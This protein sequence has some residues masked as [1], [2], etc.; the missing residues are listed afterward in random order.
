MTTPTHKK[1]LQNIKCISFGGAGWKIFYYYGIM[2]YL[3][4][5]HKSELR[6]MKIGGAS[7]GAWV[8]LSI[9]LEVD[10]DKVFEQWSEYVMIQG[11]NFNPLYSGDTCEQDWKTNIFPLVDNNPSIMNEIKNRWFA[12]I[13]YSFIK[14]YVPLTSHIKSQVNSVDELQKTLFGTGYVPHITSYK[15]VNGSHLFH[16]DGG[17]L[18]NQ[19]T[20]ESNINTL[21]IS[22][23]KNDIA[24]IYPSM[25]LSFLST[26]ALPNRKLRAKMYL[27][28]YIDA[29]KYFTL[30]SRL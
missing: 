12:S 16:I 18:N 29:A 8:A 30:R 3:I 24:D 2:K 13:C 20:V 14:W 25:D 28:G 22:S 5:F 17:I 1:S 4:E 10:P 27:T 15:R 21:Y 7:A 23:S 6:R 11:S 26:F 9:I 19:P